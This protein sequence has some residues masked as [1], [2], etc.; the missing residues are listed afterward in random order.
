[1]NCQDCEFKKI[2]P[3]SGYVPNERFMFLCLN[4]AHGEKMGAAIAMPKPGWED[5]PVRP[6]VWCEKMKG[7]EQA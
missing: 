2:V 4:P 7:E 3:P 5:L 6:P 1:M